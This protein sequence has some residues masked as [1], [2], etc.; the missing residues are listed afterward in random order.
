MPLKEFSAA[1]HFF[2]QQVFDDQ[3]HDHSGGAEETCYQSV[4]PVQIQFDPDDASYDIDQKK[5]HK[6]GHGIQKQLQDPFEGRTE[7][8]E[9]QEQ[10]YYGYDRD[11]DHGTGYRFHVDHTFL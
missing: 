7:Y 6:P 4:D 11:N 9:K 2:L 8:L 3:Q 1:F 10:K 5:D